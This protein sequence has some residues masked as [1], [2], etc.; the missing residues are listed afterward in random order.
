MPPVKKQ[1]REGELFN[2]NG[3]SVKEK[4]IYKI[5]NRYD[6]NAPSGFRAHNSTKLPSTN[7][8][9][10]VQIPFVITNRA[11][12]DGIW[13]TGFFEKSPCYAGEDSTRVKERVKALNTY[14]VN[15]FEKLK[16]IPGILEH[17]NDDFW[18]SYTVELWAG[19]Y[20]NTDD[21]MDLLDLYAAMHSGELAPESDQGNP[22][23]KQAD[24]IIIDKVKERSAKKHKAVSNATAIGKFYALVNENPKKLLMLLKYVGI[25]NLAS[26]ADDETLITLFMQWLDRGEKNA[27]IFLN[28]LD[29]CENKQFEEVI[30]LYSTLRTLFEKGKGITKNTMGDYVYN[31]QALGKDLKHVARNLVASPDLSDIK[32]QILEKADVK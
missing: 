30:Y 19:R 25:S 15:P 7:V 21:P 12:N 13:D 14:V 3:L 1:S 6:A 9:N 29:E 4:A 10:S 5:E 23:Y 11:T 22:K 17:S 16:G 26:K 24:Y 32:A 18:S 28:L 2:V 31:G 27:E 8:G 20:F